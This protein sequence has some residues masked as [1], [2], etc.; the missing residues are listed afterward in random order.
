M[1]RENK[2]IKT[3]APCGSDSLFQDCFDV[4]LYVKMDGKIGH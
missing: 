4:L 3:Q 2:T 1:S